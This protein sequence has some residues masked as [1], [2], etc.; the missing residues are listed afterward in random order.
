[1]QKLE[2]PPL[3][4]IKRKEFF[5][6][7][8][9]TFSQSQIQKYQKWFSLMDFDGSGKISCQELTTTLI[10]AGILKNKKEVYLMFRYADV[11][12][13]Q[14]ICL[15]EFLYG[16]VAYS[17]ARQIPL[18]K[19]EDI[20]EETNMLSKETLIS[21]Q[22]RG[23]LIQYVL[24]NS[25]IRDRVVDRT[26]NANNTMGDRRNKYRKMSSIGTISKSH[27]ILRQKCAD[28]VQ[29]IE[30]I[31][32][33][34]ASQI[35]KVCRI[36]NSDQNLKSQ[37]QLQPQL[38]SQSQS[39]QIISQSNSL[40]LKSP[41]ITASPSFQSNEIDLEKIKH[42]ASM[43]IQP[44]IE[45]ILSPKLL[46]LINQPVWQHYS[47]TTDCAVELS[48]KIDLNSENLSG[49]YR[50]NLSCVVSDDC[51]EDENEGKK[52][53]PPSTSVSASHSNFNSSDQV[54][55]HPT[56]FESRRPLLQPID[57]HLVSRVTLTPKTVTNFPQSP[58]SFSSLST[59]KAS[60]TPL[61][62][63]PTNRLTSNSLRYTLP[64]EG[65]ERSHSKRSH[66]VSSKLK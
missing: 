4:P 40:P 64:E 12:Y 3:D 21:Q 44:P 34:S 47:T 38:E 32:K 43:G 10:S 59:R 36:N 28:A 56:K 42:E 13:S 49:K 17:K 30:F 39:Q 51:E 1:M 14:D 63:T 23:I 46:P 8:R 66:P 19:L 15:D 61:S 11:D 58:H 35:N 52:G 9:A 2:S 50:A 41:I 22:R 62:P 48:E 7:F 20:V 16:I 33:Q 65:T 24:N 53:S 31:V 29:Q 27:E 54:N 5:R 6:H 18:Q 37:S 60:L 55:K 45:S 57:S 25:I 26:I